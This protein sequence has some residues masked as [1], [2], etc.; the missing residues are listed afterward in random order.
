MRNV[1]FYGGI[2]LDGYLADASHSLQWLF[3][4]DD[5][6]PMNYDS[7]INTIDTTIMGR[8]TFEESLNYLEGDNP[9]PDK[10]NFV[11]SRRPQADKEGITFL[12]EDP[13]AFIKKLKEEEGKDIW[14]VGG[15][16]LIKPLLEENL[17]DEWWIQFAPVLLGTGIRLFEEGNYRNYLELLEVKQFG[18]FAELHLKKKEQ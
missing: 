10:T 16:S 3:D 1:V 4:A 17:I 11:F 14:V 7:F 13:V 12:S 18:N 2:S 15:G 6:T 5:G 9:Y 8:K